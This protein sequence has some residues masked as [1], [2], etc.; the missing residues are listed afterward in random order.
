MD[1]N[2]RI[3]AAVKQPPPR[4]LKQIGGGRLKGKTDINPQWRMEVMTASFGPCGVGWKYS[5]DKLWTEPGDGGQV[6]AFALVSLFWKE[7]EQWSEA[8]PG[9]GGSMLITAETKALYSS[10]EAFKMAVTDALSVA[11]KALGV[12]AD[13]YAGLW[14]GTKYKST[15]PEATITGEQITFLSSLI[16][17]VKADAAKFADYFGIGAL[18]ELPDGRYK[19]AVSLLEAKRARA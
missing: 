7:G 11:F 3:W 17:E 4:A 16:L 8:I 18:G 2:L 5:I 13:I 1:N 12:A 9:I 15:E 14:D 19:Q 10:D 6:F